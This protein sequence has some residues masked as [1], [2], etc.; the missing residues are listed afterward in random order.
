MDI[1]LGEPRIY[2][3]DPRLP[4]EELQ[5]RADDKKVSALGSGIGGLSGRPK[6]EEVVQIASQRRVEPFWHVACR[7]H[8]VYDRTRTYAI[9]ASAPDVKVVTYDG[10]DFEV[11]QSGKAPAAFG[12]TFMEHCREDLFDVLYVDGQTG[13]G[14]PDGAAL[15]ASPHTE[16]TDTAAL[17]ADETIVVA[18][19]QRASAIIRQLLARLMR[20]LQADVVHEESLQIE[21]VD[22]YYRPI[23]AF[24]YHWPAKDKRG[25][26]EI[27]ALTG[28][29]RSATS[30]KSQFGKTL[31]RDALFDIGADA[32]GLIVP[33]GNI[34]L[35]V[36]RLAI[37]KNY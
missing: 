10:Q 21:N 37:D 15:V 33:G 25:V 24:E 28:E 32:I 9:P 29:A 18:P 7:A 30:L 1:S 22:L 23:W 16:V 35:K 3:L 4:Q 14:L 36:A 31:S 8:Y 20:P 2:R 27:D 6:T 26:V 19:E 34:A 17:A 5:R 12:M 13:A 11:V